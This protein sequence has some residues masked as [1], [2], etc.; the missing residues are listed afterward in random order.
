MLA[1]ISMQ[2]HSC[3]CVHRVLLQELTRIKLACWEYFQEHLSH[4]ILTSPY[5]RCS[6]DGKKRTMKTVKIRQYENSQLSAFWE[7]E[8]VS[9]AMSLHLIEICHDILMF[10]GC[11]SGL[12]IGEEGPSIQAWVSP[13]SLVPASLRSEEYM[14]RICWTS[15]LLSLVALQSGCSIKNG[16]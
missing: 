1:C 5:S 3:N 2:A 13:A 14:Y 7:G 15:F 12:A 4:V 11:H 10:A 9:Y 6:A 8:V 16:S